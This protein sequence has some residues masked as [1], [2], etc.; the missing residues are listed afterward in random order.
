MQGPQC[1]SGSCQNRDLASAG[2][3][4]G[5]RARPSETI[6]STKMHRGPTHGAGC[7]DEGDRWFLENDGG[8]QR[9]E[10]NNVSHSSVV[11]NIVL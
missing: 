9:T 8:L 6:R 2:D 10:Q 4:A 7:Q 1:K 3:T 5:Y 11:L